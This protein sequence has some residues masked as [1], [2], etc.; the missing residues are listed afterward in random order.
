M[1]ASESRPTVLLTLG[2]LPKALDLARAFSSFG[3]RVLVAEP[4]RWHL[5]RVS[6]AVAKCF[7]V[8]P[9][10]TAQGAYLEALGRIVRQENVRL[11]VPVSE[12]VL[13]V[14]HLRP[15]LAPGVEVYGM[16]ADLLLRL[17]NK[18]EFPHFVRSLGLTAP[19]TYDA[20]SP[21]ALELLGRGDCVMK[22]VRSCS[23]RGLSFL[24]AGSTPPV[25]AEPMVVQRR[26]DGAVLSTFSIARDGQ[27]VA[28]VV[29]RGTLMAGT[30]A[31]AFERVDGHAAIG[32]WIDTF[33]AKTGYSGFVS[34][35]FMVDAH[36]TP[37][38][39]ECNP[40]VTSGI[41][42]LRHEDLAPIIL[43]VPGFRRPRL[44]DATRLQQFF[45]ALTETQGSF[46]TDRFGR[47]LRVLRTSRDVTWEAA[48]PLPLVTMPL[49]SLTI[50]V[51]AAREGRSLGEVATSD[52]VWNNA[53]DSPPR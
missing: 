24:A 47:N 36:G 48:D 14:A 7:V 31:V 3:W 20:A 43:G 1:T 22:P 53:A 37:W 17:H 26:V 42:F 15:L 30:V 49:T 4:Y 5:C 32:A 11:V 44:R 41:H 35:D 28:S 33:V 25:P 34:F 2:R 10:A 12:E 13:H 50:L 18:L 23:G 19:E 29:Y 27:V 16:A 51:R 52:I 46:F 21:T 8:P 39:I 38:A 6:R 45:P 40:R 9:P